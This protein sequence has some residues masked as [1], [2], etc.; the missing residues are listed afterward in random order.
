MMSRVANHCVVSFWCMSIV[1]ICLLTQDLRL[2]VMCFF[3]FLGTMSK[4]NQDRSWHLLGFGGL[5][6]V[7]LRSASSVSPLSIVTGALL[8][9]AGGLGPEVDGF[10][11]LLLEHFQSGS[12][13]RARDKALEMSCFLSSLTRPTYEAMLPSFLWPE[14][15]QISLDAKPVLSSIVNNACCPEAVICVHSWQLCS[16][17]NLDHHHA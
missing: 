4:R 11:V 13:P 1:L 14:T 15:W 6:L 17:W 3:N 12:L 7:S 8:T 2:S 5:D 16:F 10:S 9:V